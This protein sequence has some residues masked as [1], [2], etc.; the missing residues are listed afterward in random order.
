MKSAVLVSG[1][2]F[3]LLVGCG[4]PETQGDKAWNEAQ[5][6]P[7]SQ[8]LMKQKEAYIHYVAAVEAASQKGAIP[9]ELL[10]KYLRAMLA[11]IEFIYEN[12]DIDADAVQLL[13]VDI[14]E[15]ILSAD[16]ENRDRYAKFLISIAEV[17][18]GREDLTRCMKE[19]DKALNI[20][21][22]KS[23]V[24]TMTKGTREAF[25]KTQLE[26]AKEYFATAKRSKDVLDFIRA[27]YYAKVALHYDSLNAGA[28]NIVAQTRKELVDSYTAYVTAV[29]EYTDTTLF[30]MINATPILMKVAV[31]Q[32]RASTDLMVTLYNDSYNAIKLRPEMFILKLENGKKVA[33]STAKFPKKLI[34]QSHDL[35][36]TLTFNVGR[37]AGK[38]NKLI[39]DNGDKNQYSEKFF[40]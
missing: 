16:A 7:E 23:T 17:Y 37:N 35:E 3:L 28:S 31:N 6:L 12:S 25:A 9:P 20:A 1:V 40:H 29:T 11:R 22:D 13:R 5:T 8:K 18:R 38:I 2:L 10:N 15:H 14:D 24:E 4:G 21:A 36:G 30:N 39:F 33:A 27:E 34:D 32:K 26:I 19:L